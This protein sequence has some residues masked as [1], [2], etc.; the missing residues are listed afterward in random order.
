[1]EVMTFK[2]EIMQK[3]REARKKGA[4][5]EQYT[6]EDRNKYKSMLKKA[7]EKAFLDEIPDVLTK[8]NLMLR[9]KCDIRYKGHSMSGKNRYELMSSFIPEDAETYYFEEST[10]QIKKMVNEIVDE[11]EMPIKTNFLERP[12]KQMKIGQIIGEVY[13]ILKIF[14]LIVRTEQK[15][16]TIC[17]FLQPWISVLKTALTAQSP[18]ECVLCFQLRRYGFFHSRG[19]NKHRD[20]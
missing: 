6:L 7:I 14:G 4:M 10:S 16:P 20:L 19:R 9:V 17:H 18:Q 13:F 5:S 11:F 8:D 12:Y 1:M 15:T 3:A 2:E